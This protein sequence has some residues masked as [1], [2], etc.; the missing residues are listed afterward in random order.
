M[1]R[2]TGSELRSKMV[3]FLMNRSASGRSEGIVRSPRGPRHLLVVC[4]SIRSLAAGCSDCIL[5]ATSQMRDR[6]IEAHSRYL[7]Y[8]LNTILSGAYESLAFLRVWRYA[9]GRTADAGCPPRPRAC[10]D[11]LHSAERHRGPASLRR[12]DPRI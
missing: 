2:T 11:P 12:P 8:N 9:I 10:P 7:V 3:A 6:D 5:L 4:S 1:E